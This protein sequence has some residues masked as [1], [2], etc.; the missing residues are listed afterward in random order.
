[1]SAVAPPAAATELLGRSSRLA[2]ARVPIAGPDETAG[3]VREAIAGCVF[4]AAGDVAVVERGRLAGVV[5]IERLLAAPAEAAL[6]EIMD[7]DPPT[8]GPATDQERAAWLMVSRGESSLAVVD[9]DGR[10]VGLIPPHRMLSVLLA[11][12]DEDLARIG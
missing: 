3:A 6:R 4:D 5:P 11:E 9:R 1:M 8:V 10:F 7:A 12:H 2:T